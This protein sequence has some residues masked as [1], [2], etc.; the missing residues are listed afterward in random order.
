M[1]IAELD[2]SCPRMDHDHSC[3]HGLHDISVKPFVVSGVTYVSEL[4]AHVFLAFVC[5]TRKQ[6]LRLLLRQQPF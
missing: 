5:H 6:R 3:L 2:C 1:G 4:Y